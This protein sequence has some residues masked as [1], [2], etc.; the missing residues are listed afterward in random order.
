MKAG[1]IS[2]EEFEAAKQQKIENMKENLGYA[3]VTFTLA[4]EVT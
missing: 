3:M 1:I 2:K 4:D